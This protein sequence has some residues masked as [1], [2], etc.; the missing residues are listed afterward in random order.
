V[1]QDVL[2]DVRV[3]VHAE[4]V[5]DREQQGVGGGDLARF[6][7]SYIGEPD[8]IAAELAQDAAVAAADTVLV[9]VPN[10]LGVE[11]NARILESIVKDIVP[12]LGD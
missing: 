8:V 10:Q 3:V 6:G 7:R 11:F 1:G 9:T 12:A 2:Q 5:G 4:L